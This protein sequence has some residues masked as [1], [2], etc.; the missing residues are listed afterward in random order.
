[1]FSLNNC[2]YIIICFKHVF[3]IS[4]FLSFFTRGHVKCVEM[5]SDAQCC[6]RFEYS[7]HLYK[8]GRYASRLLLMPFLAQKCKTSLYICQKT[9]FQREQKTVVLLL[10][11]ES[12]F[13]LVFKPI[14]WLKNRWSTAGL[15]KI[16]RFR[17]TLF[18]CYSGSVPVQT[19]QGIEYSR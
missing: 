1:M 14:N 7:C 2:L 18:L 19:V 6:M 16:T 3:G 17:T 9:T 13:L 5:H 12:F 15:V 4:A 8:T 11:S 10:S